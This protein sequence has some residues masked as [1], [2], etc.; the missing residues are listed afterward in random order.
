M[1]PEDEATNNDF[2]L[3][4]DHWLE[5]GNNLSDKGQLEKAV[6]AS[7]NGLQIDPKYP[8]LLFNLACVY[9]ELEKYSLALE[10][11]NQFFD[12]YQEK[13]GLYKKA[14]ILKKLNHNSEANAV[15]SQAEE[16]HQEID[17]PFCIS[18]RKKAI[19]LLNLKL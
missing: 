7:C 15:F 9:E 2:E 6:S 10:F 17:E 19:D 4:A 3:T 12:Q 18:E 16:I 14:I 13:F 1:S 8:P 5:I 11:L